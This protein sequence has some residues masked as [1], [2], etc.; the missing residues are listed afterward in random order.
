M[1]VSKNPKTDKW[2]VS[3]NYKDAFGF[4]K[5]TTKRGFLL[6]REAEQYEHDFFAGLSNNPTITFEQLVDQYIEYCYSRRKKNTVYNKQCIIRKHILPYFGR[7]KICD[8]T[9]K[10]VIKWQDA[11]SKNERHYSKTYI[12]SL[13]VILGAVMNYAMRTQNLK[14]NPLSI[15]G[16]TGQ[17]RHTHDTIWSIQD[18]NT[19][20]DTLSNEKLCK[21]NQI[22]RSVDTYSL[23]VGYNL[24]FYA[25]LRLGELLALTIRDV[26]FQNNTIK[27]SKSYNRV[28][29]EDII[30]PP[31]THNGIRIID[32][33]SVVMNLLQQY[34]TR[35]PVDYPKDARLFFSLNK[36]NL[37]RALKTTAQLA[38]LPIIRTHDLRHSHASLLFQLGI[39][40]KTV[41]NRLGHSSINT[42]LDIYT[43][44]M[45][46]DRFVSDKLDKI[47]NKQ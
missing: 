5:H 45:K 14:S 47:V 19:F 34:I 27:I 20:I 3:L 28:L 18:F 16:K 13:N 40:A 8:I 2:D 42:T 44:I 15:A 7:M 29:K 4:Y 24:L 12:Y 37:R 38:G 25:G 41:S 10:T 31:K 36:N 9:P 46:G 6:K 32:L 33:P 30:G 11:L 26:D 1:P 17:Y 35:L 22:K 39:P 23:I 21:D 43:H